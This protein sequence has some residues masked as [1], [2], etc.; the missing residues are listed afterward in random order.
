M[1]PAQSDRLAPLAEQIT[2]VYPKAKMRIDAKATIAGYPALVVR[3]AL[4]RL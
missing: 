1:V 3:H 2:V 4:R